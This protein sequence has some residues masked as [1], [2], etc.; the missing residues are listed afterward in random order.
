MPCHILE[1][2]PFTHEQAVDQLLRA[3]WTDIE[4]RAMLESRLV[5]LHHNFGKHIRNSWHLWEATTPLSRHYQ[6]V[7]GIGHADDMSSLIILDLLA[8]MEGGVFDMRYHVARF[9]QFW[10]DQ[11]IDPVSQRELH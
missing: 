3:P 1:T 5:G 8:R 11:H 10:L 2:L 6:T 4:R 9:R 7:H